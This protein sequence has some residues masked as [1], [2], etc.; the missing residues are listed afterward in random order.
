MMRMQVT[1]QDQ[2]KM[3]ELEADISREEAA[4]AAVQKDAAASEAAVAKIERELEQVGGEAMRQQKDLVA[5]VKEVRCLLCVCM[6]C[7]VSMSV[8]LAE[9][10]ADSARSSIG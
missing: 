6:R 4:L 10:C 3:G 2:S 1:D 8:G 5:T 7:C 9:Y